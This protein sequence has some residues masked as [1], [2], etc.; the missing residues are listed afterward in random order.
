MTASHGTMEDGFTVSRIFISYIHIFSCW[1]SPPSVTHVPCF[2]PSN[3]SVAQTREYLGLRITRL[4][5][6]VGSPPHSAYWTGISPA[7]YNNWGSFW[8]PGY[9]P[10]LLVRKNQ[11]PDGGERGLRLRMYF[12][13]TYGMH[14]SPPRADPTTLVLLIRSPRARSLPSLPPNPRLSCFNGRTQTLTNPHLS[15]F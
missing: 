6:V 7:A 2:A 3:R 14:V 13:H 9:L 4:T 12:V 1:N 11:R 8:A 5:A 15:C 10:S